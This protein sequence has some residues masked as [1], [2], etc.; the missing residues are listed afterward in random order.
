M[1][2]QKSESAPNGLVK[3]YD[4]PGPR[5]TSY[6]TVPEWDDKYG[7]DEY[8]AALQAA[9]KDLNEPLSFYLHIPFCRRRCWF[10]GCN[11]LVAT[12]ERSADEY[13]KRI[14]KESS[15]ISSILGERRNISQFH[16]GG[17]TPS[18]L[19][20]SQTVTVFEIFSKDYNIL[21]DAEISIEVDP[22]V[23][24][25]ERI[26]L[27]KSL[28]FNRLSFGIQDFDRQVQQAIG[29]NQDEQMATELYQYCRREGY[30]GINFDLVY[31]LPAQSMETFGET[32]KKVIDL[33]PDRVA[34]YSFAY[35][36]AGK[37]HQKKI[38]V[39]LLPTAVTKFALFNLGKSRFIDGGY[40]QIGMDHFVLPNDE[41]ALAA[42]RGKLRRNFM[43]YTVNA[44]KDWIGIGASSISYINNNFAQ[45]LNG[46]DSYAAAIDSGKFATT[47]GLKLTTD[48]LIRQHVISEL[49]CNFRLDLH[50]LKEKFRINPEDY[51]AGE[52]KALAPF[53]GDGLLEILDGKITVTA[54]GKT[55]VRNIAM[56]FD[57]YLNNPSASR[58]KV[59][60]SRTV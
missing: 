7:P 42:A 49:M 59:Q 43:G 3:K 35:L 33:R 39:D 38:N 23:T 46:I 10:C 52:L 13:I 36:P 17:G 22:R 21:R 9:S 28:G 41:L 54:T 32:L 50:D 57:A 12:S 25:K 60:F 24:P 30:L 2:E 51:L 27:L 56:V 47:K 44:A 14:R 34:L 48:D 37:A 15:M 16:W 45:N 53:T 1:S 11:T 6:P 5:Y 58:S 20:D 31:G 29:R 8:T 55:F 19:T 26:R 18:F 40:V 4:R